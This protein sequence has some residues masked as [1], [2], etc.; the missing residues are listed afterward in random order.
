MALD[1][2]ADSPPFCHPHSLRQ[3]LKDVNWGG[4]LQRTVLLVTDKMHTQEQVEDLLKVSEL[5]SA[6]GAR[7][8]DSAVWCVG[9]RGATTTKR[10]FIHAAGLPQLSS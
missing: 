7:S 3:L 5:A 6:E 4:N 10:P 2:P 9:G 8:P 1:C